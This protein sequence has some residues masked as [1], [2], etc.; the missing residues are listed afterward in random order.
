[1][2]EH[3][4]SVQWKRE[5]ESFAYDDYN[6]SHYWIF[7]N[8]IQVPASAAT[9]FLGDAGCVDPEE[10]FV[11]AISS[12]HMLTFL[13]ICARKR[14]TVNRYSDNAVGYME[15]NGQGKLAI[16]RVSLHPEI[17]WEGPPPDPAKVNR[18][19]HL[20]HEECFIANSVTTRIVVADQ[21]S[22]N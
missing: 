6:R 19:H 5:S 13:A 18:I 15:Q 4:A 10:A 2:S 22:C 16:T 21:L 7:Q 17:A 20:S 11:A 14:I 9:Q 8:G 12:C 1:M 3:H